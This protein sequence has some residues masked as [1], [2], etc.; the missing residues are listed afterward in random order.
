M[1]VVFMQTGNVSFRWDRCVPHSEVKC[2]SCILA[3]NWPCSSEVSPPRGW[4]RSPL[5]VVSWSNIGSRWYV[6][7]LGTWFLFWLSFIFVSVWFFFVGTAISVFTRVKF[8]HMCSVKL[9]RVVC[10]L[11]SGWGSTLISSHSERCGVVGAK[12]DHTL[13]LGS[14]GHLLESLVG[15]VLGI[16]AS[17]RLLHC[18][19]QRMI[20]IIRTVVRSSPI[21]A[22]RSSYIIMCPSMTVVMVLGLKWKFRQFF[23]GS[24]VG[25]R[26][27][28]FLS[29]FLGVPFE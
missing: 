11:T 6:C 22:M 5:I 14:V 20:A 28:S 21:D 8:V 2:A 13:W 9:V 24:A 29:P 1:V 12:G 10:L 19:I 4:W 23:S 18:S 7:S 16:A 15:N 26:C 17:L 27:S 25:K 3:T